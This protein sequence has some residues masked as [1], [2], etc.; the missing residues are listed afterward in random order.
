[1]TAIII[2]IMSIFTINSFAITEDTK[3]LIELIKSV[4]NEMKAETKTNRELIIAN[5]KATDKRFEDMQKSMDKRFEDMQKSMDKRFVTVDK[6]FEDMNK[7]F[8]MMFY[9]M[10]AGFTL[11]FGYLLKER[12]TI[13]KEV[14]EDI[15]E[16]L[17]ITLSQKADLNLVEK[18]IKIL[19]KF[20]TKNKDIENILMQHNLQVVR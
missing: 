5:Q 7:R 10:M 16:N 3:V 15:T 4:R 11:L 20:A 12:K 17:E 6:R 18:I 13:S 9:L 19:K 2:I 1:M 8:D 14:K